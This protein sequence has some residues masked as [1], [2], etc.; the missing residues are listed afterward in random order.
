MIK[1]KTDKYMIELD[2]DKKIHLHISHET[3]LA[4]WEVHQLSRDLSTSLFHMDKPK[5]VCE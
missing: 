1:I 3:S 4:F 5:A 2:E